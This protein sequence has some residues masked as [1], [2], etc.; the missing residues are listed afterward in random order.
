MGMWYFQYLNNP[1][2]YT[3]DLQKGAGL[4]LE[5]EAACQVEYSVEDAVSSYA[6][7]SHFFL[8]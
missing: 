4:W 6:P 2:K 5:I 3:F 7:K 1:H 8:E